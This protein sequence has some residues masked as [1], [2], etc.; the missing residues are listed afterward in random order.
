MN[1]INILESTPCEV[2]TSK[3]FNSD[4]LAKSNQKNTES[5]PAE[6]DFKINICEDELDREL[7]KQRENSH[8]I[9]IDIRDL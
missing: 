3:R 6:Q 1:K 5:C 9:T 4:E 8:E 2:L 7:I